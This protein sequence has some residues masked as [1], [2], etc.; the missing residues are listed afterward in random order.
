[1]TADG[2]KPRSLMEVA[3]RTEVAPAAAR[4]AGEAGSYIGPE[5]PASH[6]GYAAA[7][8]A[9]RKESVL[10]AGDNG[11][12][13][14]GIDLAGEDN[15]QAA[16]A[17]VVVGS[18]LL[19]GADTGPAEGSDLEPAAGTGPDA[20]EGIGLEE[21]REAAGRSLVGEVLRP[22]ELEHD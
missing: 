11:H 12:L 15:G 3:R 16:V 22:D 4:I 13:A 18:I 1:M 5:G 10:L 2:A 17:R 14:E 21:D 7:E 20:A 6:M 9:G 19:A 8:E